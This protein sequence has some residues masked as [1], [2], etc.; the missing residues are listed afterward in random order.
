MQGGA[1]RAHAH[2]SR[3]GKNGEWPCRSKMQAKNEKELGNHPQERRDAN[4]LRKGREG[5]IEKR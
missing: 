3:E 1:A 5:D 2:G 4:Y